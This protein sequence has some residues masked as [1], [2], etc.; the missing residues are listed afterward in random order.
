MSVKS[1]ISLPYQFAVEALLAPTRFV[2]SHQQNRL[3]P[4]IK[5]KSHSPLAICRA[6]SQFLH[7]GV[8][9]PIERVHARPSQLWSKLLEKERQ[10]QDLRLHVLVERVEFRLKLIGHL[11]GP[12]HRDSMASIPL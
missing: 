2:S 5:G 9:G 10:R 1:R 8:A 6:E 4:R 3:P 11:N 12:A 7:V